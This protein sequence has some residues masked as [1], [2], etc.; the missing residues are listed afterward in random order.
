MTDA[1]STAP[2]AQ[3]TPTA[4][5]LVAGSLDVAALLAT[6]AAGP[7]TMIDQDLAQ[8]IEATAQRLAKEQPE[9]AIARAL[10]LLCGETRRWYD[11][12]TAEASAHST[13]IQAFLKALDKAGVVWPSEAQPVV[14]ALVA[15]V[16]QLAARLPPPP[17]PTDCRS[18]QLS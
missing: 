7:L 15:G 1:A 10:V 5:P 13:E 17:A 3:P 4:D 8:R 14:S 6:A 9:I 18:I 16:E 2:T 11:A 12:Y